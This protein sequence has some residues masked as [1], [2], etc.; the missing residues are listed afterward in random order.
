MSLLIAMFFYP[1]VSIWLYDSDQIYVYFQFIFLVMVPH[2][3]NLEECWIL[4][5]LKSN[6]WQIGQQAKFLSLSLILK[7]KS[8]TQC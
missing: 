2:A 3:F 4:L 5:D 1:I 7:Y 6:A 8:V